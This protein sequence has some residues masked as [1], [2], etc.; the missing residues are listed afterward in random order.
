MQSDIPFYNLNGENELSGNLGKVMAMHQA[1][2]NT[3]KCTCLSE[4][5]NL[6]LLPHSFV[7]IDHLQLSVPIGVKKL[8][9][10]R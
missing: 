2:M 3:N 7:P 9:L 5:A 8:M 1:L 10:F 6:M 4:P